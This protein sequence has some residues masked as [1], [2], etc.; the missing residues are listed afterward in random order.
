MYHT[1]A[2][3]IQQHELTFKCNHK[4]LMCYN[5]VR[6]MEISEL[7]REDRER[8]IGIAKMSVKK[9]VMA[10]C[11]TGGEPLLTG[12]HFFEVLEIYHKGGCYTS[13]NSNGDLATKE[14]ASKLA[15]AGL[16]SALISIHGVNTLHDQ[17]VG[18]QGAFGLTINGIRNLLNAGIHVVPNFVAT[19][20]NINGL[21]DVGALMKELGVQKMTVTPFLPS[22]GA[23]KHSR[24]VLGTADYQKYFESVRKIRLMG[25][26]ID[27]TLP[28]P[29]CVLIRHFP[30]TWQGYLDVHSPRVCM[31]GRSFG[32]ISPDGLFRACIQA[33]YLE[34]FGGSVDNY[35][36]S[37]RKANDWAEKRL[38]PDECLNCAALAVCGGGCRTSS[39]WENNGSVFGKTMYMGKPLTESQASPFISR[40]V[41]ETGPVAD[42]Y[43]WQPGIK[44]RDEGWGIIVFNPCNQSFTILSPKAK[45]SLTATNSVLIIEDSK[46]ARTLQA[47]QAI[48]P[49]KSES[50]SRY[51]VSRMPALAKIL[52]A[53]Y[54]LP[55]LGEGLKTSEVYCLR[56][57]TGERFFPSI[58]KPP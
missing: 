57:D 26:K 56:A 14:T 43:Q 38:I 9:G 6:C 5:Q 21:L 8:N 27:S 48:V 13:M 12:E 49:W 11:L 52:P 42:Y 37:W 28:I 40:T 51:R 16:N 46:T 3:V 1:K 2:P 10:V 34:D 20:K 18:V 41:V 47:M 35:D 22:Y 54:L 15:K 30:D 7:P 19:T 45:D 53:N 24:F 39:L 44:I 29:P 50:N 31:A 4:C 32:V 25:I 58:S 23:S 55:R 36:A 17:M 33:P